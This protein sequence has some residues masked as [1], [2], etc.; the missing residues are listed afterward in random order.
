MKLLH[1]CFFFVRQRFVSPIGS[2][3]DQLSSS[4]V[5]ICNIIYTMFLALLYAVT[6]AVVGTHAMSCMHLELALDSMRERL[7]RVSPASSQLSAALSAPGHDDGDEQDDDEAEYHALVDASGRVVSSAPESVDAIGMSVRQHVCCLIFVIHLLIFCS[8]SSCLQH[9]FA[10]VD[11]RAVRK[12]MALKHGTTPPANNTSASWSPTESFS[13]N[14]A[15]RIQVQ[16]SDMPSRPA[17][18]SPSAHGANGGG[19]TSSNPTSAVFSFAP[20]YT[21]NGRDETGAPLEVLDSVSMDLVHFH[22]ALRRH[23]K[24]WGRLVS[25]VLLVFSLLL[26]LNAFWTLSGHKKHEPV[27]TPHPNATFSFDATTPTPTPDPTVVDVAMYKNIAVALLTLCILIPAIVLPP[28]LV[29]GGVKELL[30]TMYIFADD[31]AASHGTMSTTAVVP[32]ALSADARVAPPSAE[33]V[34][35]PVT[36]ASNDLIV[37]KITALMSRVSSLISVDALN[38]RI[39]SI[40]ISHSVAGGVLYMLFATALVL[41][42]EL[43]SDSPFSH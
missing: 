30:V 6:A 23:N 40:S 17:T 24:T 3:S 31:W 2:G 10:S 14:G 8:F 4:T 28:S 43:I 25:V 27:P 32:S 22:K 35:T 9:P 21:G 41:V 16:E 33:I 12:A 29:A 5:V 7:R 15:V 13:V 34:S 19:G 38:A 18:F 42:P 37:T 39:A 11:I 26:I 36:A 20:K 1:I